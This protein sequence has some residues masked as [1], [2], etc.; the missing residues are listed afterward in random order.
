MVLHLFAFIASTLLIIDGVVVL[1]TT[2]FNGGVLHF[3]NAILAD[4]QLLRDT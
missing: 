4:E 1:N 3:S 2:A